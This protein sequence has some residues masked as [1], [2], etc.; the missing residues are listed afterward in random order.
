MKRQ[1]VLWLAIIALVILNLSCLVFIL[2]PQRPMPPE[3]F[4]SVLIATL[5]LNKEQ[6]KKFDIFKRQHHEQMVQIDEQMQLPYNQYFTLLNG[7]RNI[8][9]ED[10]LSNILATLYKKKAVITYQHFADIKA[11]C[12]ADQQQNFSRLVPLL[13]NV[14]N[15]QKNKP[16]QRGK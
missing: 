1:K 9:K 8:L 16:P 10:S 12:N 5:H 15:P 14:I 6:V 2:R 4:D 13:M 7:N 11:L 3:N